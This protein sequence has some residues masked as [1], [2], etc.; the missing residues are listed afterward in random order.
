[1]IGLERDFV[2]VTATGDYYFLSN[3]AL[4]IKARHVLETVEVT[5]DLNPKYKA[6]VVTSMKVG[7]KE[8]WSLAAQ[9]EMEDRLKQ[10]KMF[11]P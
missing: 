9:Q 10:L 1:M 5:G 4:G 3:V 6:M 11:T 2:L 8:V 7:V